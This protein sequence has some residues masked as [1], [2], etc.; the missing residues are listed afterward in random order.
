MET[1]SAQPN[2][3][4][5]RYLDG[6]LTGDELREFEKQLVAD[7][8]MEQ[9]LENL[10]L[11]RLAVQHY[12]LKQQVGVMHREMME[13]LMGNKGGAKTFRLMRTLT[14]IAA[15][16]VIGI[17]LFG[18]YEYLSVSSA[19]LLPQSGYD[20]SIARSNASASQIEQDYI[21]KNY[22]KVISD[23]SAISSP[24]NKD[25]FLTGLAYYNTSM[26]LKAV[27]QFKKVI[28]NKTDDN[29][30]DDAEYYLSLSY[31]RDNQ[32]TKAKPWLEKIYHDKEHLY[33]DKVSS[34]TILKLKLLLLK[35]PGK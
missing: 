31:L 19:G 8:L 30:R 10:K 33:H 34:W 17:A 29:Y 14:R 23:F 6:E 1:D 11:A 21:A 28:D 24:D 7:P 20:L 22:T 12:G 27:P 13:E 18:G 3:K 9:E 16:L 35:D 32:P 2:D 15:V 26:P 25:L 4:M 5:I